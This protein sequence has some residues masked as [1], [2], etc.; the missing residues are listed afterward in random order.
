MCCVEI[1]PAQTVNCTV[2]DKSVKTAAALVRMAASLFRHINIDRGKFSDDGDHAFL[3][4]QEKI[5]ELHCCVITLNSPN[6]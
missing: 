1:N 6:S 5:Q 2:I 4:K 3:S